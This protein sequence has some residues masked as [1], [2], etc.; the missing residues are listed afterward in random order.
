MR[1]GG[2]R[3][4]DLSSSLVLNGVVALVLGIDSSTQSSKALLVDADD[5]RVL[6]AR[7]APHPAGTEV[8]ENEK[9]IRRKCSNFAPF[10]IKK[11]S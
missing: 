7:S 2:A 5:G 11:R 10:T 8:V 6:E 4:L 1:C 3:P 9:K